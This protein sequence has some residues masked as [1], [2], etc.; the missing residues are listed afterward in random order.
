MKTVVVT[1]VIIAGLVIIGGWQLLG[2][3]GDDAEGE[4][5]VVTHVVGRSDMLITVTDDGTLVSGANVEVKCEV[6]GGA[7]I[8]WIIPDGTEVEAG[9][10]LCEL[11]P[12]AI[13]DQLNIQKSVYEKALATKIQ[14][15]QN[16]AAAEIAVREYREG[17]Y[18]QSLQTAEAQIQI[19]QQN[20]S[21]AQNTLEFTEKMVRKGFTTSLQVE[22]DTSAVQRAQLDLD[23]A[24]TAKRVLEEFTYEKMDKQLVAAAEA[25]AAQLRADTATLQ[26]E[27]DHLKHLETQLTKCVIY[28]PVKGM[29]IYANDDTSRWGSPDPDIYEGAVIRDRQAI[30]R[31]PDLKNMQVKTTVHESKVNQIHAGLPARIVIQGKEYTGRVI[32]IANQPEATSFLSA[33]VKEYGTKVAID[34]NSTGLKPGMTA[35][36]EIL[37]AEIKDA[38]TLPV[39]A[40]VEKS[41]LFYCYLKTKSGYEERELK[42]G[43]TNDTYIEVLDGVKEGDVVIRNPRAVVPAAREQSSLEERSA[44]RSQ[45]G[46]GQASPSSGTT[47]APAAEGQQGS[48]QPT[49]QQR[50]T[51]SQ[52]IQQSDTDKD[53]KLS[54]DEVQ[55]PFADNFDMVDTD[56]DGFIAAGELTAAFAKFRSGGGDRDQSDGGA[57][58]GQQ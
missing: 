7:T 39:T 53:G 19:A 26:N 41:G 38:I 9:E 45:F 44:D 30:V 29:V 25:A 42:L 10:K 46:E 33:N 3:M 6:A 17:L 49:P 22:A 12:A 8:L 13:I 52:I 55:G 34:G 11:D 1:L 2:S 24:I 23:A 51:A 4:Q 28:S 36:V 16:S 20:L 31:L 57:A 56:K 48:E 27:E 58:G 32:G 40:V 5:G 50:P 54:K 21:S 14:S 35:Q 15:E 47:P 43:R 18:L 37:I